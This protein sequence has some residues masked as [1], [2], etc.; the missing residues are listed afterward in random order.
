MLRFL[1]KLIIIIVTK[2][3][4]NILPLKHF[5]KIDDL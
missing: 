1:E 3:D 5:S 2:K 4:K